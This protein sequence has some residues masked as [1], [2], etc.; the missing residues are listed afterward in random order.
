MTKSGYDDNDLANVVC[1]KTK[2][3]RDF[4]LTK[5][6]F[7]SEITSLRTLVGLS[8]SRHGDELNVIDFGGACGAHYFLAKVVFGNKLN[9]RWH[10]VETP[11]M[12]SKAIE[13]E[14]GQLRFF[15]NIQEAR[16]GLDRVDLVFSSGAL[17]YVPRPYE[18]LEQLIE[19]RADNIFI[20]RVGLSTLQKNLIIVQKSLLSENGYGPMPQGMRDRAVHYPVTFPRKDKFED[21]LS[22][23]YSINILFN[24]DKG[25][26]QAGNHT[27]D[28]YGYFATLKNGT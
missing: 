23:S 25:A 19:C 10:V 1:K 2:L 24:E 22:Q 27:V 12:T 5:H 8:L 14:D 4:L 7:V 26:Y 3:Y 16:S 9:L 17:Q 13:L 6:P 20:T 18:Y 11:M 21:I 28:M 15:D